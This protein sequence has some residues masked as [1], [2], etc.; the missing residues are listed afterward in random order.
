MGKYLK[1]IYLFQLF[2]LSWL[3]EA[4]KESW[5]CH[6]LTQAGIHTNKSRRFEL[7][8][9]T[10]SENEATKRNKVLSFLP[11]QESIEKNRI[12]SSSSMKESHQGKLDS[13]TRPE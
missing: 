12:H 9:R 1:K 3:S 6:H 5:V 2:L 7:R 13:G 8:Q 11:A 4:R 10:E